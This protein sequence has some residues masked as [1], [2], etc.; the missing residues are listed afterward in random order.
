MRV[1]LINSTSG[2]DEDLAVFRQLVV[3]LI[4]EQVPV[5]QVIPEGISEDDLSAFGAKL[6]WRE[7]SY[8][9]IRSWRLRKLAEAMEE[10]EVDLIHALSSETWMG[11]LHAARELEAPLALTANSVEDIERAASVLKAGRDLRIAFIVTT[12]PLGRAMS[13]RLGPK[14][15]VQ[16]IP[17]GAHKAAAGTGTV[18]DRSGG[19][20]CAVVAGDGVHDEEYE[21]LLTALPEVI[22]R[23]P[24]AQFF[25]DGQMSD[26]HQ[27]WQAAR[28]LGLLANLSMVPR[29]LGHRE[30]LLRADVLI[31]PQALGRSRSLTL[32]AM[33]HG[34]PVLA[35]KDPWLDYLIEGET[36][37][38]LDRPEP[39]EWAKLIAKLFEQP[40]DMRGLGASAREWVGKRHVA[41]KQVATTLALYR[42]LT[43][44]SFKFPFND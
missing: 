17:P 12:S 44:E 2:I 10:Q 9:L 40:D 25:L 33:L 41:A 6:R 28:R 23:Y 19:E 35:L 15:L 13:E 27:L 32:Q 39:A 1:A 43:G 31:Q 8:A 11:A 4:D 36:A 34:L 37:L 24:Q 14:V 20:L 29:K 7:S 18:Y 22:K 16:V 30:L 3:G 21:A 5:V 26:Q 42:R 38:L